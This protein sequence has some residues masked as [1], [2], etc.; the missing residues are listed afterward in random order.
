M[1]IPGAEKAPP[2]TEALFH[3]GLSR[4]T[5]IFPKGVS[6]REISDLL[7]PFAIFGV[8]D[9]PETVKRCCVNIESE[10]PS[11]RLFDLDVYTPNGK[12]VDRAALGL[13]ARTCLICEQSAMDCIRTKRHSLEATI[14]KVHELLKP[15][16]D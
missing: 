15:Y 3:W 5:A 2:G 13:T 1:N 10:M 11:A 8:N 6:L 4:L 9:D 16:R 7:G 14:D 12:Q